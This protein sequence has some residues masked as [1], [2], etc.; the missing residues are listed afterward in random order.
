M[1]L[2]DYCN[3]FSVEAGIKAGLIFPE[4]KKSQRTLPHIENAIFSI[5]QE[6]LNNAK[7]HSKAKNIMV[8]FIFT[9]DKIKVEIRDDGVGFDV[10]AVTSKYESRRS[11]GLVSMQ[12][13]AELL[14]GKVEINSTAGGGTKILVK[15][16]LEK[17]NNL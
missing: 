6:A 11:L 10:S 7:K 15:L 8:R 17:E 3:K 16:P 4:D 1:A 2:D 12:E 14:G 13:R 9:D 5:I